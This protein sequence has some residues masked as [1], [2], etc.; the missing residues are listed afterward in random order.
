MAAKRVCWITE[1]YCGAIPKPNNG[2]LA[3]PRAPCERRSFPPS[4]PTLRASHASSASSPHLSQLQLL[5]SM[6]SFPAT[7]GL[8]RQRSRALFS[9]VPRPASVAPVPTRTVRHPFV[10]P[11]LLLPSVRVRH[12]IPTV[13][14]FLL[15]STLF[16][17]SSFAVFH[18]HKRN[19]SPSPTP[20]CS[21][22][23]PL[24]NTFLDAPRTNLHH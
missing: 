6:S 13:F 8:V 14:L 16:S 3:L 23:S 10:P 15:S 17:L 7:A 9:V 1:S 24:L 18:A 21:S 11:Y 22:V 12:D 5:C 4:A 2:L 20:Q 19:V